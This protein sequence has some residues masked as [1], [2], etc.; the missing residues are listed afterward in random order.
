MRRVWLIY[1]I[2]MTFVAASVAV[3]YY[4]HQTLRNPLV[5]F[6]ILLGVGAGVFNF[7][8]SK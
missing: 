8:K 6:C 5:I 1:L 4:H 7:L 3:N 2:C